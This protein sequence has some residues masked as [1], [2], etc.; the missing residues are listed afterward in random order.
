M[1]VPI[2]PIAASAPTAGDLRRSTP[3]VRDGAR[4]ESGFAWLPE[5]CPTARTFDPCAGNVGEVVTATVTGG[6][7]GG[8]MTFSVGAQVTAATAFN[9]A[10][11]VVQANVNALSNVEP[12]DVVVTGP[13]GGPYV[14]TWREDYGNAPTITANGAGLTGGTAPAVNVVTTTGGST[15]Y[16]DLHG[17]NSAEQVYHRPVGFRVERECSTMGGRDQIDME[18]V[19]KQADAVTSFEMARELWS[20]R[21][22]QANPFETP[23]GP[24]DT[25]RYLASPDAAVIAGGFTPVDGIGVLE[26]EARS[27]NLGLDVV[28]HV[29]IQVMAHLADH[30]VKTGNQYR[31]ASGALVV[32]DAG[33]EG[34]SPTGELEDDRRWI[35]ATSLVNH[36]LSEIDTHEFVNHRI[37]R[38][39]VVAERLFAAY[40]DPCTHYGLAV[41]VPTP[42]ADP[43]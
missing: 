25:N 37:N 30:L 19:R 36:R 27:G 24:S 12:G 34:T 35:Y 33:Y 31:T 32:A 14:F 29:P 9:A 28:I 20:G 3:E 22:T 21:R 23:E 17:D 6:P 43:A 10:A 42:A 2:E 5:R 40:F 11:S 7:T 39:V 8:T 26:E 1:F 15:V 41:V 18:S 13:A 38:R 16:G 4:W